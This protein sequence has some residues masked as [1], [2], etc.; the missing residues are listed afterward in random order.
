MINPACGAFDFAKRPD[1]RLIHHHMTLT[2]APL[3]AK[4]FIAERRHIAEGLQYLFQ[5]FTVSNFRFRLDSGLMTSNFAFC[6]VG[7]QPFVSIFAQTQNFATLLQGSAGKI[8][9]GVPLTSPGSYLPETRSPQPARER[10]TVVYAEFD[11]YFQARTSRTRGPRTSDLRCQDTKPRSEVRRL[12]SA[13]RRP[14]YEN[15]GS[16]T[17]SS[18]GTD[19]VGLPAFR[20]AV[21]PPTIT[22]ALK[23]CSRSICATRALVASRAQVQ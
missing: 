7:K 12:R 6:L 4:F 17:K 3:R 5:F 8:V 18:L 21:R 15:V 10:A 1:G 23:P 19:S 13:V 20:Q 11:L 14:L 22:N 2:I 16:F 9:Q